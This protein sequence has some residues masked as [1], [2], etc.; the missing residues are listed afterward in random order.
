[1]GRKYWKKRSYIFQGFVNEN[2]LQEDTPENP[3]RRFVISPSIFN[4]IKD[5]LMDP[6]IQEM[7]TDYTAGLDFRITKTTKGQY[8]DYSTSKWA[9]KETA[10]T[11]L[12]W[13]LLK[14]MAYIHLV[15]SSLRNLAK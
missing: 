15:I 2:P 8:A 9:R 13:Q 3:I 14:Q 4:L 11:E 6:D 12:K 5:A 10:L 7:P 1:M